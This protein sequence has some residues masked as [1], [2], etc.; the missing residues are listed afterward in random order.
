MF[1]RLNLAAVSLLCC[2]SFLTVNEA[3]GQYIS[4]ILNKMELQQKSLSSLRSK[5]ALEKYDFQLGQSDFYEGTTI[6][7]RTGENQENLR[8]EWTKPSLESLS[9]VNGQYVIYRPRLNQAIIGKIAGAMK[10]FD[11]LAMQLSLL[12]MSK[13]EI[14]ANYFIRYLGQET[15]KNGTRTW[16]LE[17]TPRETAFYK[18]IE[19]WVEGGG[20]P[21]Q[22]KF[23]QPNNDTTTVLLSDWKQN[24]T[25]G[26]K[27]FQINLPKNTKIIRA[28]APDVRNGGKTIKSMEAKTVK[29]T[30][31]N[32]RR[33]KRQSVKRKRRR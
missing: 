17:L 5:I 14:K 2:F 31:K 6:F 1:S 23:L 3:R 13:K 8:I 16:H 30:E 18:K 7:S 21:V 10:A 9:V 33:V 28:S 32:N 11:D 15:L 20:L 19:F 22:V 29:K 4:H 24:E 25:I 27:F 26:I 12:K